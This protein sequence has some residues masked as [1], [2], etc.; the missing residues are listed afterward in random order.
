MNREGEVT[1]AVWQP[2]DPHRAGPASATQVGV[3]LFCAP[4]VLLACLIIMTAPLRGVL[5]PSACGESETCT[6][7]YEDVQA[8]AAVRLDPGR[9][10]SLFRLPWDGAPSGVLCRHCP[11]L[12][13][14]ARAG[15]RMRFV[16]FYCWQVFFGFNVE[17][18]E[19]HKKQVRFPAPAV[20]RKVRERG[21]RCMHAH[22]ESCV[23]RPA[24]SPLGDPERF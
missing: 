8:G 23:R 15:A 3:L 13:V 9:S 11:L 22:L 1:A 5:S 14:V 10:R 4:R 6:S 17:Q 2:Q 12:S 7:S 16:S 20:P 18:T 19:N 24:C 21:R